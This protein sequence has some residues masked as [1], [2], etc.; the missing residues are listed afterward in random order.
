MYLPEGFKHDYKF[1]YRTGKKGFLEERMVMQRL[2]DMKMH[3]CS[4]R[5][6]FNCLKEKTKQ[7]A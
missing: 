1:K 5:F 3:S 4:I 7:V 6:R 2:R